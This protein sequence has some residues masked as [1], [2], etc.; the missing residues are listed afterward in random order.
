[1]KR[2]LNTLFVTPRDL[3][4]IAMAKLFLVETDGNI[5][6]GSVHTLQG[7]VCFGQVSMSPPL[8]GLCAQRGVA[9]SFLTKNGALLGTRSRARLR[10]CA[11]KT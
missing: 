5:S 6:E 4:S 3:I 7:I 2:L 11:S 10:Q 9:V 1:M 8:I